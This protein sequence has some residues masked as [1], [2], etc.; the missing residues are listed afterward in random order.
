MRLK[1]NEANGR[2][3]RPLAARASASNGEP[4]QDRRRRLHAA[5]HDLL[6]FLI[7]RSTHARCRLSACK[8]RNRRLSCAPR[9]ELAHIASTPRASAGALSRAGEDHV[10]HGK[11]WAALIAARLLVELYLH[12]SAA[13]SQETEHVECHTTMNWRRMHH[14]APQPNPPP[15]TIARSLRLAHRVPTL[16]RRAQ[17][18]PPGRLHKRTSA[19]PHLRRQV[20]REEVPRG[21][22]EVALRLVGACEEVHRAEGEA[23]A[24]GNVKVLH[25]MMRLPNGSASRASPRPATKQ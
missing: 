17:H 1:E 5:Q 9:S 13:F 2:C 22:A 10:V 11:V 7:K 18:T 4:T 19:R 8:R 24:L 20:V 14:N 3:Q 23:L 6:I 25:S 15:C 16:P 12:R 21:P